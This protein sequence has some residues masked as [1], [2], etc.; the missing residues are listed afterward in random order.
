MPYV[1]SAKEAEY[2]SCFAE[3]Q[4]ARDDFYA[5]KVSPAEFIVL[6]KKMDAALNDWQQEIGN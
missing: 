6:R 4:S 1:M 2:N 3:Y 5:G